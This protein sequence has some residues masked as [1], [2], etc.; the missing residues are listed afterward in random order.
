M[1][2]SPSSVED[3]TEIMFPTAHD[4]L[5]P[6]KTTLAT[7][8]FGSELSP[9]ASQDP[10]SQRNGA[11]AEDD[12]MD[13]TSNQ[14]NGNGGAVVEQSITREVARRARDVERQPGS[15]WNNPRA[16]EEYNRAMETV[17][18]QKFNLRKYILFCDVIVGVQADGLSRGVW[19]SI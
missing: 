8:P 18:D 14:Q 9:P 16:A 13:Y 19:G 10:P 12:V 7:Q 11:M 4:T 6:T 1:Q 2:S 15:S 17:V 3:E 5:T